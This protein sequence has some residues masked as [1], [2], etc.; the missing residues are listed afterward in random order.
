MPPVAQ[1][2]DPVAVGGDLLE[3]RG[4]DEKGKSV[5]AQALDQADDLG[6]GAHIDAA[7][8]LIEDE[9]ARF[10]GQPAGEQGLLLIAAGEK[11]DGLF[12]IR[13]ADVEQLDEAV[14]DL[15]LLA[16]R[17]SAEPAALGLEREDDVFA[18]GEFRDDAFR[19]AILRA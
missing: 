4:D 10:G 14:G 15:F 11:P 2:D 7:R 1:D 13:R 18:D 17:R 3:L 6:M 19:L 16:S 8:R 12:R 9:E 5:L